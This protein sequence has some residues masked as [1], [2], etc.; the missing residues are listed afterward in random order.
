MRDVLYFR[1]QIGALALRKPE[2]GWSSLF[3]QEEN[4]DVL[5]LLADA[6]FR[7]AMQRI[8]S[9]RMLRFT[10]STLARQCGVGDAARLEI[11]LQISGLFA[12]RR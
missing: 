11:M 8:I 1:E 12:R 5:R 4:L 3:A 2:E 6:D 9:R 7:K 10:V